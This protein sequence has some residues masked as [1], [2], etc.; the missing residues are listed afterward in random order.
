MG[1]WLLLVLLYFLSAPSLSLAGGYCVECHSSH[2]LAS[3]EPP[4]RYRDSYHS[5][6]YGACPVLGSIRSSILSAERAVVEAAAAAKETG[7]LGILRPGPRAK[8]HRE[9]LA[10]MEV[11]SGQEPLYSSGQVLPRLRR[12]RQ[13]AESLR[14]ELRSAGARSERERTVAISAAVAGATLLVL[15]LLIRRKRRKA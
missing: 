4:V 5:A 6:E 3:A 13:E 2:G 14:A 8:L 11:M 15:W 10:L 1:R 9:G 12:I 7:G